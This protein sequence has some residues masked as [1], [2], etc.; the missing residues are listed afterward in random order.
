MENSQSNKKV[1]IFGLALAF[2]V[3]ALF[4]NGFGLFTGKAVG[5][6]PAK[7]SIGSSPV[8]GNPN[9]KVT[10]YEFS[11]FSC[12]IC[13][14]VDGYNEAAIL[15]I[16]SGDPNWE[17]PL[18]KIKEKYVATGK[19]KIVFKY[20]PGHGTARPAHLVANALNEQ[21]LFWEFYEKAFANQADTGNIEKMKAIARGLGADMNKLE[22]AL[23]TGKGEDPLREDISMG[24]SIGILGTPS[25]IINGKKI[26]GPK[27]LNEFEKII[28]SEL[29]K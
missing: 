6:D 13:A 3:I 25:F 18:P 22:E 15:S 17:A 12:P 24:E 23:K 28:E 1:I 21:G 7:L 26:E 5:V 20:F 27:S 9:A 4:T 8:L 29:A 2:L 16:K 10:I 14:V 11:D 19:A